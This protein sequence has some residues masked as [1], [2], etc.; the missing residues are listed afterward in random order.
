MCI[1]LLY[2]QTNILQFTNPSKCFLR[3]NGPGNI[4]YLLADQ[5]P[6]TPSL[7]AVF[8]SALDW[9]IPNEIYPARRKSIMRP[10]SRQHT[11]AARLSFLLLS[12]SLSH[13]LSLSLFLIHLLSLSLSFLR[14]FSPSYI[15]LHFILKNGRFLSTERGI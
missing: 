12:L 3:V 1:I 4:W 15:S 14:H 7:F 10:C 13:F 8:S 2:F 9:T 5:N 6:G 11:V